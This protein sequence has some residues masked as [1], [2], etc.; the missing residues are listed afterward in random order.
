MLSCGKRGIRTPSAKTND[1]QSSP[2][3]LL[4]RFPINNLEAG[5]GFEPLRLARWVM[6]PLRYQLLTSCNVFFNCCLSS[7]Q[8]LLCQWG[9]LF[10]FCVSFLEL[11]QNQVV[12]RRV[13][14]TLPQEWKSC[15][16]N[17]FTNGPYILPPMGIIS[18]II[19]PFCYP[20]IWI[21]FYDIVSNKT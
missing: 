17:R 2:T 8:T 15:V 14:E 5:K 7:C 6:S 4:R 11:Y 19:P 13:I 3:L 9:R 16:L 10:F 12:A 18:H 20:R 21:F 1:L